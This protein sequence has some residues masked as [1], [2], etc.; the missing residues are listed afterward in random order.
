MFRQNRKNSVQPIPPMIF[1][2]SRSLQ[3]DNEAEETRLKRTNVDFSKKIEFGRSQKIEEETSDKGSS[4]S[5]S[6]SLGREEESHRAK[7]APGL[8]QGQ[9][10]KPETEKQ[11]SVP[12][13]PKSSN[14][15]L[16]KIPVKK[17][18]PKPRAPQPPVT[19]KK[20]SA[21]NSGVCTKSVDTPIQSKTRISIQ[22]PISSS[23]PQ[24][25]STRKI[26]NCSTRVVP[27]HVVE[28]V[29]ITVNSH[30]P[31]GSQISAF[32]PA[33]TSETGTQMD[34]SLTPV[35]ET[36]D[37]KN[38]KEERQVSR[39]EWTTMALQSKESTVSN[40]AKG[41]TAVH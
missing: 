32:R 28:S 37:S 38:E 27:R 23:D 40:S 41:K 5:S 17:V 34:P 1:T 4:A 35:D 10:A 16:S 30:I 8:G 6:S 33:L 25:N 3:N 13:I 39:E 20:S 26:P 2:Q 12:V 9:N 36:K 11:G 7:E 31:A 29:P 24:L 19:P 22:K 21:E 15:G 18:S 14:V